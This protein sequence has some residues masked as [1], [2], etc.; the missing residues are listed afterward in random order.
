MRGSGC[1]EARGRAVFLSH[2]HPRHGQPFEG[3]S[4]P[5]KGLV[6]SRLLLLASGFPGSAE[7]SARLAVLLELTADL[8]LADSPWGCRPRPPSLGRLLA[9]L[10]PGSS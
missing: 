1:Q 7:L 2:L 8:G 5:L 3:V 9:V 4:L 10:P 6:L